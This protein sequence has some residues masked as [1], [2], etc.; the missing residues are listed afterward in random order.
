[1]KF[2][3]ACDLERWLARCLID[4]TTRPSEAGL[5]ETAPLEL[6]SVASSRLGDTTKTKGILIV[7]F[8]DLKKAC[9]S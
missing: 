7:I 8:K 2:T 3:L 6:D 5:E 9:D 1:M 4:I